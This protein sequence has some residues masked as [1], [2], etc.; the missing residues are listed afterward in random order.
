MSAKMIVTG[1]LGRDPEVR[2]TKNGKAV[3]ELQVAATASRKNEQSNQW[4]DIGDALWVTAPFWEQDAERLA[5]M[6]RKGDRVTI[7]GLLVLES[8][9]AQ[10]G[11]TRTKHVLSRPRF[12]G[13]IPKQ[14]QQA[15]Q[16]QAPSYAQGSYQKPTSDPWGTDNT[17]APF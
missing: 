3:C 6:V 10:D 1:N 9:T 12:L 2:Y 11:T 17:Q 15:P 13:V 14:P 5:N 16:Q 4:E 7:E 8:Y